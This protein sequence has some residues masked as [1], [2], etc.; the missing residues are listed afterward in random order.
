[1]EMYWVDNL[2]IL[3]CVDV[4]LN[5]TREYRQYQ[6]EKG[7]KKTFLKIS[8]IYKIT[9]SSFDKIKITRRF[10]TYNFSLSRNISL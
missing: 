1:M 3:F 2:I 4:L 5:N 6:S 8:K 9:I 7:W 10:S